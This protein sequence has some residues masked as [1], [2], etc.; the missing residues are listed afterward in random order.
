[1]YAAE[2]GILPTAIAEPAI[3]K[4]AAAKA[5]RRGFFMFFNVPPCVFLKYNPGGCT[6]ATTTARMLPSRSGL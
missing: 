6:I 4:E 3:A 5:R 2:A 1:L